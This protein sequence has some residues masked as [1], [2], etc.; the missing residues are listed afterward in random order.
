MEERGHDVRAEEGEEEHEVAADAR[1]VCGEE[2][3][4]EGEER[5]ERAREGEGGGAADG[6]G[7]GERGGGDEDGG[8]GEEEGDGAEY[9]YC[10]F[11]LGGGELLALSQ[12]SVRS[13]AHVR[14]GKHIPAHGRKPQRRQ[15]VE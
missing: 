2:R 8:D 10:R 9:G 1:D 6:V 11:E 15:V 12:H 5:D 7:D 4:R 13:V 14:G 3:E